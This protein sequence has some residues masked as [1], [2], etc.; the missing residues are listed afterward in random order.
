MQQ[1]AHKSINSIIVSKS[2]SII[3]IYYYYS[4]YLFSVSCGE[5]KD[6]RVNVCHFAVVQRHQHS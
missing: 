5:D 2:T 6:F 4:Y 1:P 3:I